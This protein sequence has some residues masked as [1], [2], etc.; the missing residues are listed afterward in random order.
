MQKT[1]FS[2]KNYLG[3]NPED[4]DLSFQFCVNFFGMLYCNKCYLQSLTFPV[5]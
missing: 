3:L 2:V 5:F 1:I 4:Y